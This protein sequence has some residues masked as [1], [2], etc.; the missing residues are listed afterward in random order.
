MLTE[1]LLVVFSVF[2]LQL[3]CSSTA[4][5]SATR[6]VIFLGIHVAL[7]LVF[8]SG[9]GGLIGLVFFISSLWVLIVL[10]CGAESRDN[11]RASLLQFLSLAVML[12]GW[13]LVSTSSF[14]L[15]VF[16]FE[17]MTLGA[18]TMLRLTT[19][20]ERGE[21]ALLEMYFWALMGSFFLLLSLS[22]FIINAQPAA[23]SQLLTSIFALS[24]FA[25]K[26][27]LWPFASWLLKAHVEASTEFSIFLSGFLVKFGVLGLYRLDTVCFANLLSPVVSLCSVMGLMDA[28][29]RML[30]Q[31][32]LKRIIALLTIVETN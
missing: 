29:W 12:V 22:N 6:S 32:D 26:V 14:F 4:V 27:P 28:T 15:I 2:C 19:K 17:L 16:S 1:F 20:G 8:L 9:S 23:S 24:G 3:I 18:L 30:A 10:F 5:G 7:S 21:E 31:V 25:I 13:I 11:E